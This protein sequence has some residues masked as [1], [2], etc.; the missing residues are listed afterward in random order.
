LSSPSAGPTKR[1]G[2][3][4]EER[5]GDKRQLEKIWKK[6]TKKPKEEVPGVSFSTG[7]E[8]K[9]IKNLWFSL[10]SES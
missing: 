3:I 7:G 9:Y 2:K 1:K 5:F 10:G 6:R 4:G 8:G